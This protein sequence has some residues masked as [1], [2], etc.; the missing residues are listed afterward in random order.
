MPA[1]MAT[2]WTV[3]K[4]RQNSRLFWRTQAVRSPT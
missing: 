3:R 2:T 4:A 1:A